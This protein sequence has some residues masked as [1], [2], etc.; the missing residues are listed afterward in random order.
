MF[1]RDLS[2]KPQAY[3]VVIDVSESTKIQACSPNI[4]H[5]RNLKFHFC[6]V[7]TYIIIFIVCYCYIYIICV[8][9]QSELNEV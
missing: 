3:R 2:T 8:L 6:Y 5:C 4:N 7:I 1:Q 9:E